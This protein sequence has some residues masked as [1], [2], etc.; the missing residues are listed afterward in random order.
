MSVR[1]WESSASDIKDYTQTSENELSSARTW[2]V[3]NITC[4]QKIHRHLEI[5]KIDSVM[6]CLPEGIMTY[7]RG[8]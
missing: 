8:S 5:P 2:S 7:L 1:F 6:S 4:S 3:S